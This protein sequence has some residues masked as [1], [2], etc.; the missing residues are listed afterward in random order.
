MKDWGIQTRI[1][2][3]ALVPLVL[4]VTL[5][6]FHF[7]QTRLHDLDRALQERGKAIAHQMAPACEYGVFSGNREFLSRLARSTLGEHDVLSVTIYDMQDSILAQATGNS[8]K[9]TSNGI[10]SETAPV[11]V[12]Q[13][14]IIQSEVL[15]DDFR[16]DVAIDKSKTSN[17]VT[18]KQLGR[19]SVELSSVSTI[20]RRN[21]ILV[22]SLLIIVIGLVIT[23]L[24]ALRMG[25]GVTRPVLAMTNL[26]RK[27]KAGE[28][29]QRVVEGSGAE[30]GTLERGINAMAEAL[31]R[32]QEMEKKQAEDTLYLAKVRAQVTLESIGDG[33]ITTDAEGRIVYINPVAEQFTGWDG[34]AADGLW[35]KDVFRTVD[36]VSG[37]PS[38]YPLHLCL[39]DGDIIRHDSHHLLVRKDGYRFAIQDS[40]APIRDRDG[41]IIGAAV[42][43]HDMTEMQ[44]MAR[45][46]AYLASHDPLTGLINR[47]EFEARLHQAMD[48]ARADGNQHAIC[49]FD[50]DQF[51]IVNDTCGHV[52]GDELLK[53]LSLRLQNELRQSDVLA[54]LGGDEFGV[55]LENC[56]IGKAEQVAEMLRHCIKSFRF[57]WQDHAFD[58]GASIGLVPITRDSGSLSDVMS[59]ADSACYVAKDRGRNCIHVY[60][61]DDV[62]LAHRQGEMRWVHRLNRGLE[63]DKFRIY[64][65]AIEP[66]NG[67][68]HGGQGFYEILVRMNDNGSDVILPSAF[69]PAAERY[70]LMPTI[71]RRI[72]S[73]V[74]ASMHEFSSHAHNADASIA[75]MF[76]INLS[77]Q[78]LCDDNFLDF[79][80][81]LFDY[82]HID[83]Q[84][85]CFEITETAAIANLARAKTFIQTLKAMGCKFALDDFGSGLSS[86]GYLKSLPVDYL[87]IAGNFVQD[88]LRDPVDH[89]MV[90]AINQ[91]GHIMGLITIAESVESA[92]ILQKIRE[93]GIDYGQGYWIGEP[94]PFADV[95]AAHYT[96]SRDANLQPFAR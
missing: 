11:Y 47:R 9:G 51:K 2:F 81:G 67:R 90:D 64:S 93:S 63:N 66:L 10:F 71:D 25:K 86:F 5:L 94:R 16:E 43:F 62:A 49:Y 95:L 76:S 4:V 44:H 92:E 34:R 72:I 50:L 65:Q 31:E 53:Q 96:G 69:I 30:L 57:I 77:G 14:P 91:I 61:A 15:V 39:R 36:E 21:Q 19:I 38:D 70:H 46:M 82:Y 6:S 87:K 17:S 40:A 68:G 24:I 60:Q 26:V 32:S 41:R 35:L 29:A 48:S 54:R 56:S 28:L 22:E 1:L 59:A 12:F 20:A 80:T 37:R 85:I 42:V 58:I 33:V 83:P 3:I 73:S 55:I 18:A 7:V 8:G 45:R 78:S 74:F 13:A 79:V 27:I 52:A 23:T 75:P 88:I 89:A 84:R